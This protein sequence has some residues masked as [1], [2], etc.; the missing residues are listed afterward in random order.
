MASCS[1]SLSL[2]R[3]ATWRRVITWN[4]SSGPKDFTG[5]EA[6]LHI[7]DQKD[8]LLLA[9][10]TDSNGLTLGGILG[11]ITIDTTGIDTSVLPVTD[12]AEFDIEITYPDTS[13][14]YSTTIKLKI[15]ESVTHD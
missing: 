4:T 5:C 12:N 15:E 11:T 6:R 10:D 8:N 7:R 13:I 9:L 2:K 1:P 3:G 14:E